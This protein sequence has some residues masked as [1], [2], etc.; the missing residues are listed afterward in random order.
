MV[1]SKWCIPNGVSPE[2]FAQCVFQYTAGGWQDHSRLD[3]QAASR[4]ICHGCVASGT[5]CSYHQLAHGQRA[6]LPAGNGTPNCIYCTPNTYA[7]TAD[8]QDGAEKRQAVD[9]SGGSASSSGDAGT[10]VARG[11]YAEGSTETHVRAQYAR[12]RQQDVASDVRARL[13]GSPHRL[14]AGM[15]PVHGAQHPN[16]PTTGRAAHHLTAYE[17]H[18]GADMRKCA[19]V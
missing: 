19:I 16:A 11:A 13:Q 1:Y 15:L 4:I 12:G 3:R 8:A 17:A 2:L 5:Q 10:A 7:E 6:G 9:D 14:C 18:H